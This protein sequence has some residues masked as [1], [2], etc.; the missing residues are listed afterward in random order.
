MDFIIVILAIIV[1]FI[2]LKVLRSVVKLLITLAVMAYVVYYL[3]QNHYI[4][5]DSMLQQVGL[6]YNAVTGYIAAF[7]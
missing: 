7:R 6:V 5:L 3:D 2:L 4:D 1:V